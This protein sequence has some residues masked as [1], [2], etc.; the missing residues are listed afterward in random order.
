MRP[1]ERYDL[2]I[3][4]L[5]DVEAIE[6]VAIDERIWSWNL[7]DWIDRGLRR[8]PAK[9]ALT[10]LADGDPESRPRCLTYRQLQQR[11]T[12]AANLF[13]ARGLRGHDAVLL[14]LPTVP[15]LYTALLGALQRATPCCVNWMLKPAQ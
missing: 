3:R 11:A 13:H 7:N 12:Q 4:N 15:D 5:A 10:A 2:P 14:L 6:R 9:V 1:S 8:D